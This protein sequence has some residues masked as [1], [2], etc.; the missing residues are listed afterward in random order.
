[1]QID[2]TIRNGKVVKPERKKPSIAYAWVWGVFCVLAYWVCIDL[3]WRAFGWDSLY[4][5]GLAGRWRALERSSVYLFV[6]LVSGTT[7]LLTTVGYLFVP[8]KVWVTLMVVGLGVF[9]AS[10]MIQPRYPFGPEGR[11]EWLQGFGE[12]VRKQVDFKALRA[13]AME[14]DTERMKADEVVDPL[15]EL[16]V[17]PPIYVYL[18][19]HD[20]KEKTL[21]VDSGR[22]PVMLVVGPESLKAEPEHEGG[23]V[24][25]IEPGVYLTDGN[26]D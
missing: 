6:T 4:E 20:K 1:M 9:A 17:N 25:V 18:R 26:A 12:R 10:Q 14:G 19:M 2:E 5:D 13:L 24:V 8:R 3:E 11:K 7:L 15:N 16:M 21:V 23:V 22:G